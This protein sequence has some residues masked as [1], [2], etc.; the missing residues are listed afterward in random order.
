MQ[1]TR[2]RSSARRRMRSRRSSARSWSKSNVCLCSTRQMHDL[3]A[4]R[5]TNNHTGR[6][7]Q[8]RG[9]GGCEREIRRERRRRTNARLQLVSFVLLF[10]SYQCKAQSQL[11]FMSSI[12]ALRRFEPF[13]LSLSGSKTT[14]SSLTLSALGFSWAPAAPA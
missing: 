7:Q 4:F 3:N 5:A 14:R 12:C 10:V 1:R 6:E 2:V 11:V 9:S 8:M 13:M